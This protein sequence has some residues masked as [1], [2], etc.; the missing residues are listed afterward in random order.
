[1]SSHLKVSGS[2]GGK[3]PRLQPSIRSAGFVLGVIVTASCAARRVHSLR[4]STPAAAPRPIDAARLLAG[5]RL[6]MIPIPISTA[7]SR[8]VG[9]DV[10]LATPNSGSR[11]PCEATAATVPTTSPA[12]TNAL[13]THDQTRRS[14]RLRAER[15]GDTRSR[16]SA[17][18]R[19]TMDE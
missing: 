1:M 10:E 14:R 17:A 7:A 13:L 15:H 16:A 2:H 4:H 3:V 6:A 11:D 9:R 5:P 8:G 12:A 18:R 19:C